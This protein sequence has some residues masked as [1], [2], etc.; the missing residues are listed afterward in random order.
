MKGPIYE[1][2]PRDLLRPTDLCHLLSPLLHYSHFFLHLTGLG[3]EDGLEV[4]QFLL[5]GQNRSLSL[6]QSV[7]TSGV[8]ALL[9]LHFPVGVKGHSQVKRSPVSIITAHYN[10]KPIIIRITS[11]R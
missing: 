1:V 3:E 9:F 2:F 8:A 10:P 5:H 4:E 7:Q 11:L 6:L